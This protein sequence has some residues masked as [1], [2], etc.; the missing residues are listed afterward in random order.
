[1]CNNNSKS[2]LVLNCGVPTF[3]G[4]PLQLARLEACPLLK[5]IM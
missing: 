3:P 5:I 2:I 4:F 1:M